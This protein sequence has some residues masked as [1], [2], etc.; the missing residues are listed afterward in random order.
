MISAVRVGW[1]LLCAEFDCFLAE[2]L[3]GLGRFSEALYVIEEALAFAG[4]GNA[5]ML[6]VPELLRIKAEILLRHASAE[7][8][9]DCFRHASEMASRQGALL[10]ELR[11]ALSLARLRVS[12]GRDDEA[13]KVL[14]PVYDRFTEGFATTDLQATRTMIDGL[15]L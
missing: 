4:T 9:A 15:P 13:R 8:A 2:A 1:K 7:L 3:A 10:W 6:Y 5:Q 12:Q 14:V 11:I